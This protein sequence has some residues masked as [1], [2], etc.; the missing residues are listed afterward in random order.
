VRI[1]SVALGCVSVFFFFYTLRLLI[2]T[3]FLQHTRAGGNGAFIG[4]AVFPLLA[5]GFGWVSWRLWR[6]GARDSTPA[7]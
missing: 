5:I 7:A 2:V 1:I 4:A 3:G 6:R